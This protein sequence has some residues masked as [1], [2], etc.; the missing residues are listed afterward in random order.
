MDNNGNNYYNFIAFVQFWIRQSPKLVVRYE[1]YDELITE[2]VD[3][4][5]QNICYKLAV[6]SNPKNNLIKAPEKQ[7]LTKQIKNAKIKQSTKIPESQQNSLSSAIIAKRLNIY[8]THFS[9]SKNI[10]I[11]STNP[12]YCNNGCKTF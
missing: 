10:T 7:N 9:K 8:F 11:K 2:C 5:F 3:E 12:L 1:I 6:N 4:V